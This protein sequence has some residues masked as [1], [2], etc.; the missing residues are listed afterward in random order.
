VTF[1]SRAFHSREEEVGMQ[2][3]LE[4]LDRRWLK[5]GCVGQVMNGEADMM[6]SD[7]W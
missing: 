1:C 5:G 6:T 2:W 4:K 3:R 7:D